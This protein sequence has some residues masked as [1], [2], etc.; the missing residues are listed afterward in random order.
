MEPFEYRLE[1]MKWELDNIESSIRKIDDLG[2]NTK[3]WAIVTWVGA[4]AVLLRESNLHEFI[5]VT[6]F[7]PLLFMMADAH[8]RKLQRRFIYRMNKISEFINSV[9]FD[10]ACSS[11][12]LTGFKI[13]DPFSRSDKNK[14][15]LQEYIAI[16][17][18]LRYPTVSMLYIG[19]S[20]LSIA[21]WLM[22]NGK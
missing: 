20:F 15:E 13:L 12:D 3:N 6:A 22:M 5:Y 14:K 11:K 4:I 17:R 7:P 18:I 2:N 10:D 21:I 8:W 16:V 19:Q 9:D 1:L